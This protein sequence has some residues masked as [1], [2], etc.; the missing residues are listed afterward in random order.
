MHIIVKRIIKWLVKAI[1]VF[2]PEARAH[3]LER[4]RRGHEDYRKFRRCDFV[5]GSYGKS[6]RT[7]VRVMISRYFQGAH[8]YIP[9]GII[10]G[11]DNFHKL[12]PRVPKIF[13]T[14][15]NYLRRYTGNEDSRKDFYDCKVA[16]LATVC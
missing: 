7:W 4:W 8:Q 2:L 5:F 10:L 1:S 14:H 6:G 16:L 11:F 3:D 15:D 13:F 9:D 12:N